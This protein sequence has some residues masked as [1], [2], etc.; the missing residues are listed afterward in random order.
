M[1]RL[2]GVEIVDHS[3]YFRIPEPGQIDMAHGQNSDFLSLS[4]QIQD[5]ISAS[6]G[7]RDQNSACFLGLVFLRYVTDH[8]T[9][10][11][12]L[13]WETLIHQIMGPVQNQWTLNKLFEFFFKKLFKFRHDLKQCFDYLVSKDGIYV[14]D[15]SRLRQWIAFINSMRS[16]ST[17]EQLAT[18]L[19][20]AHI[21]QAFLIN[22]AYYTSE[23]NQTYLIH[24]SLA[25]YLVNMVKPSATSLIVDY[26]GGYGQIL[27]EA[28]EYVRSTGQSTQQLRLRGHVSSRQQACQMKTHLAIAGIVHESSPPDDHQI[29]VQSSAQMTIHKQ[30]LVSYLESDSCYVFAQHISSSDEAFL[31]AMLGVMAVDSQT[32]QASLSIHM[33]KNLVLYS[34]NSQ[35][36]QTR[37]ALIKDGY[38]LAVIALPAYLLTWTSIPTTLLIISTQPCAV[39][40]VLFVDVRALGVMVRR[41][42]RLL[43]LD[44]AQIVSELLDRWRISSHDQLSLADE[45]G[46]YAKSVMRFDVLA[47]SILEPQLYLDSCHDRIDQNL[48]AKI[49]D[50][51]HQQGWLNDSSQHQSCAKYHM[52]PNQELGVKLDYSS[53]QQ[54]LNQ[55][56]YYYQKYSTG[57]DEDHAYRTSSIK[58]FEITYERSIHFIKKYLSFREDIEEKSFKQIIFLAYREKLIHDPENYIDKYR[59]A[60]NTTV[61]TYQEVKAEEVMRVIELFISDT[62]HLL[63]QLNDGKVT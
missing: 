4:D 42:H 19:Y 46:G 32:N 52:S 27:K 16:H 43:S 44:D 39:K 62:E 45:V 21:Y 50:L 24:P 58:L 37:Q 30:E 28:H 61:H 51:W 35:L 40:P 56:K 18:Q 36:R 11:S 63:R 1:A 54:A 7:D 20:L 14:I 5:L 6:A 60:R 38:L 31:T 25:R 8:P 47:T 22:L 57:Q 12:Q 10:P 17:S 26:F 55:L 9:I 29:V 49:L 41:Y 15:E 59:L 23:L 2:D 48:T 33:V 3:L 13:R 34:Q 53:L